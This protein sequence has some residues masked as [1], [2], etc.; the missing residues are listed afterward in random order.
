MYAKV[1]AIIMAILLALGIFVI[2]YRVAEMKYE[3]V[4]VFTYEQESQNIQS[5]QSS[6]QSTMSQVAGWLYRLLS[7]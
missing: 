5:E 3:N 4:S 2:G 7:L 1:T 6:S